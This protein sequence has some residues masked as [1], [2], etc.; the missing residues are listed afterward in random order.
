MS[1]LKT[2]HHVVDAP[3][4]ENEAVWRKVNKRTVGGKVDKKT[5]KIPQSGRTCPVLL[6]CADLQQNKY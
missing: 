1:S 3:K 2:A 4:Q 6:K 5:Q